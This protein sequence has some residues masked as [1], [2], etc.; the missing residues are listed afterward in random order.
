MYD[1][2]N[3]TRV[4]I[5]D[6]DY[7]DF[8]GIEFD[9]ELKILRVEGNYIHF[10][11]SSGRHWVSRGQPFEYH[12]PTHY[13]IETETRGGYEFVKEVLLKQ[14]TNRQNWRDVTSDFSMATLAFDLNIDSERSHEY[15]DSYG[16]KR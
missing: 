5:K 9:S 10:K 1:I 2:L 7:I 3:N 16:R 6:D 14:E 8:P 11:A 12:S 15:L 13:V 4:V